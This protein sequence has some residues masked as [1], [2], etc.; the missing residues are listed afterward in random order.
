MSLC[1]FVVNAPG[2]FF[3]ETQRNLLAA[4]R[5]RRRFLGIFERREFLVQDLA[6]EDP[7]DLEKTESFRLCAAGF[8]VP[9]LRFVAELQRVYFSRWLDRKSVV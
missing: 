7:V 4:F 3:R 8:Q 9:V 2:E 1:E 6:G 5:N